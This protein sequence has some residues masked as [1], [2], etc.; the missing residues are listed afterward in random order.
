MQTPIQW[1]EIPEIVQI[2]EKLIEHFPEKFDGIKADWI[3]GYAAANKDKPDG[4][5]PWEMA[6]EKEPMA[7]TNSKKYFFTVF[8]ADWDVRSDEAK[9]AMVYAALKRIDRDKPES[10]KLAPYDYKDQGELVR[11]FGPDWES[12][13]RLPHLL[14]DDI[15]FIEE[16]QGL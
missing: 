13:A 9:L 8:L 2:A 1:E 5:K 4:K 10:G 3:V 6:G 15:E 16:P 7:F 12:K 11:T 14:N